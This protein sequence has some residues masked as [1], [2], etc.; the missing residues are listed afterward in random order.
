MKVS[1]IIPTKRRDDS[2][3]TASIPDNVDE[4][5][6]AT[7]PGPS[8]ARNAG[9]ERAGNDVIVL[10]DDDLRFGDEWFEEFVEQVQSNPDCVYAARG[11][12]LLASVDW[13]TGFE[14]GMTRVMGFYRHVWADVG[15]FRQP[16]YIPEDPDY[17]SDTDFLMSAYEEG[18]VVKAIDH[19]W[20]HEDEVDHYTTYQNAQ[21]L[22]WLLAHHPR[23]VA[24]RTPRLVLN[25]L[26][27]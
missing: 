1:V 8:R 9:I 17:G 18:Y 12:G 23:L 15:G 26:V 24:P 11:D 4:V 19:Q 10:L 16:D 27:G 20:E 3:S 2:L 5:I 21:W 7:E 22:C 14:P 25:G 13:P 6:L